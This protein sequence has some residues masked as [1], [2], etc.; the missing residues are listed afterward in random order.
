MAKLE[1]GRGTPDFPVGHAFLYFTGAGEAEVLATYIVV[2]PVAFDFAKYVP[3]LLASSLGSSGILPQTSFLPI[4]PVPEPLQLEEVSRLA[5]LRGDDVIVERSTVGFDLPATMARVAEIGELYARAYHEGLARRP[6]PEPQAPAADALD[7]LALLYSTLSERERLE[8][9][10]RR[11]GTLRYAVE[12]KDH[13]LA[14]TTRAEMRAIGRY[15]P[16]RYRTDELIEAAS[17]P[18]R[19]GE[20]LAQLYIERGYKLCNDDFEA[21]SSIDAEIAALRHGRP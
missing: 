1:Y 19:W 8:E 20:R 5:E 18:D 3:P 4:P 2:P 10:A 6:K 15:L 12:G 9:I 17:W 13:A 11:A 7:G 14:E 16:E 21:I